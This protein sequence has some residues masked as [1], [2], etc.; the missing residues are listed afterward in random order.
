MSLHREQRR[1]DRGRERGKEMKKKRE[2]EQLGLTVRNT[3]CC[4]GLPERERERTVE[5]KK[6][7]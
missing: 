7:R 6:E 2:R 4:T 1:R 5:R 3:I